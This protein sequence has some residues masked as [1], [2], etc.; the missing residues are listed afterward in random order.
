M[1]LYVV[2]QEMFSTRVSFDQSFI[3][4]FIAAGGDVAPSS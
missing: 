1:P 3:V 4:V 2:V